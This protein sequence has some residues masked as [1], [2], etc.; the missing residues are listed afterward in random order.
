[1]ANNAK[2]LAD[3]LKELAL[4]LTSMDA[5]DLAP[6]IL[7]SC[8]VLLEQAAQ[9]RPS[10]KDMDLGDRHVYTAGYRRIS[11]LVGSF[12]QELYGSASQQ[13]HA[14]GP[15]DTMENLRVHM[16]QAQ[17][18]QI[19]MTNQLRSTKQELEN[20]ERT[21]YTLRT[22]LEQN[23]HKLQ[24][25][26]NFY[27]ALQNMST[28]CSQEKIEAQKATNQAL[29]TEISSRTAEL[30]TLEQE[31]RTKSDELDA[32]CELIQEINDQIDAIPLESKDLKD[33]YDRK[34]AELVQ[35]LTAKERCSKE[36]Q[37]KLEQEILELKPVVT[38]LSEERAQLQQQLDNLKD[39][40][41][42][43]DRENQTIQTDMLDRIN[44]SLSTL[45]ATMAEHEQ[46]LE[47]IRI[48]AETYRTSLAECMRIR[49]G[50]DQWFGSNRAQFDA[51]IAAIDLAE[52]TNLSQTLNV[53]QQTRIRDL[54]DQ[55]RAALNE[56]DRL[57]QN[58]AHAA[59]K[60]L[61]TIRRKA[62]AR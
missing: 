21:N 62:G 47:R 30:E 28:D 37:Q 35:L 6:L 2:V 42:H 40:K 23:Q 39:A 17:Q 45:S 36:N 59:Q 55:A 56:T 8:G 51:S 50:L 34:Q 31:A 46:E 12:A 14:N 33:A 22:T 57:L 43:L 61:D 41:V 20:M 38:A 54:F 19:Q 13:D 7:E 52:N 16:E 9:L 3:Q 27:N 18:E 29:L 49:S 26:Q 11:A 44:R 32:L 1:M 10:A 24:E 5:E 15:T 25:L 60:D 48:Q 53:Q 58:C 4:G